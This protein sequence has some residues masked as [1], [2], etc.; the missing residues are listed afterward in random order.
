MIFLVLPRA[1]RLEGTVRAP[2]SKSATNRALV[3]AALSARPVEIARPLESADTEA[4]RRCLRAMGA[5]VEPT[6]EGLSLS[7]PLAASASAEAALDA[8]DSGTAARFLTALAAATPGRFRLDGSAGLR[9]RPMG[10]LVEALRRAGA[11]IRCA[12]E[13]GFLPLAISGATLRASEIAV[14]AGRSS[15]FLSALLL[16]AVAVEG[17]LA[18][19]PEGEVASAPYVD[20]TIEALRAFGHVVRRDGGSIAVARGASGPA[21]H[22]VPGDL[23]SAVPLLAAAG[24]AAGAVTVLG[25][26]AASPAADARALPVLASMGIAIE[27]VPGGVRATLEGD[28]SLRAV[29]AR[30]TDF[31]DSVPALAALAALAEGES[32]FEGIAHLRLKESDRIAALVSLLTAAGATVHSGDSDLVITGGARPGSSTVLPTFDDHR[33]AMAASLISLAR[34]GY[35]LENPSCVS[36][37]Y[38]AYF[39]DLSGLLRF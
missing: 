33:I 36:K 10:E 16:C 21:R 5:R 38:P 32:R 34:G 31:P 26:S 12:G 29:R 18:V 25:V 22:E 35:L 15:Q 30:A 27:E 11:E 20:E 3:L 8:G 37:S 1:R 23:S 14:D 7:G 39:R 9:E 13:E 6:P 4:M 28:V 17:G 24:A 2:S 19:R